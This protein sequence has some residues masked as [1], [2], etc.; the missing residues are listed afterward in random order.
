MMTRFLFLSFFLIQT[1]NAADLLSAK[2]VMD[3]LI[4]HTFTGIEGNTVWVETWEPNKKGKPK[5][6]IKGLWG[7]DK[8][9]YSGSW[10]VKKDGK[11]CFT[12][13]G[14]P[15]ANGCW[16]VSVTGDKLYWYKKGEDEPSG[17]PSTI[18]E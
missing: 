14:D 2:Q 9:K 16:Y 18:V 6:K 15:S 12:Y 17:D 11:M 13:P 3:Q 5:G 8:E 1:A 7:A 4:G 10:K